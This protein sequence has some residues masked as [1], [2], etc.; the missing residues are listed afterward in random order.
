[1][2]S[3]TVAR[4]E[5]LRQRYTIASSCV[6]WLL[7]GCCDGL[8]RSLPQRVGC[9]RIGREHRQERSSFT[10]GRECPYGQCSRPPPTCRSCGRSASAGSARQP[11]RLGR[12]RPGATTAPGQA[13]ALVVVTRA[14]VLVFTAVATRP[15]RSPDG[16][17]P[18]QPPQCRSAAYRHRRSPGSRSRTVAR[19]VP[20]RSAP[21]RA[22]R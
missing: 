9:C 7:Q 4:S 14:C 12:H 6:E 8:C 2:S 1:M 11:A 20:V 15:R 16:P 22:P 18:R 3:E 17:S 10:V 19:S 21:H 5:F 13:A